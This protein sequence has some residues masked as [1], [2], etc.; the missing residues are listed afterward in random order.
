[1]GNCPPAPPLNQHV[2][3]LA[4]TAQELVINVLFFSIR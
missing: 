1:M 2:I 4:L 3:S